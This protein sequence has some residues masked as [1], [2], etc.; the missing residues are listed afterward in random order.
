[1]RRNEGGDERRRIYPFQ[2]AGATCPDIGRPRFPTLVKKS[3]N[4]STP[5]AECQGIPR[6]V[7]FH[8]S[9]SSHQAAFADNP[10]FLQGQHRVGHKERLSV[11]MLHFA[12]APGGLIV[13][14]WEDKFIRMRPV[15]T[16]QRS[17][18]PLQECLRLLVRLSEIDARP[19]KLKW[20]EG[21]PTNGD[22]RGLPRRD[23]VT[24][25]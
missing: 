21:P 8:D 19:S 14:G 20:G 23:S 10:N 17:A 11:R 7:E 2:H 12:D 25:Y 15:D 22:R 4:R 18:G 13:D 6:G 5:P 16:D 9:S 1:M 24:D 3:V